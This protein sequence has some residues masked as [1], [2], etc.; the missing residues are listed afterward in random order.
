MSDST[1]HSAFRRWTSNL[2]LSIGFSIIGFLFAEIVLR[3]TGYEGDYERKL[4]KFAAPYSIV[5]KD[6]WVLKSDAQAHDGKISIGGTRVALRKNPGEKRVLLIGDS[7]TE[8]YGVDSSATF[9]ARLGVLRG[10]GVSI[11][12]AGVYGFN[13]CDE[14]KLYSEQLRDLEADTVVLGLFPAN[15][16]NFNLLGSERLDTY[17]RWIETLLQHAEDHSAFLHFGYLS[18]FA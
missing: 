13:T 17:P 16:L 11:L 14:Y 5:R 7:V 8:G 15:D 9:A 18:A 1:N 12:N 10:P 2:G 6:S 4:F 3:L